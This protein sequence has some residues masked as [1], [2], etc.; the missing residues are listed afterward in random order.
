[1]LGAPT[2]GRAAAP[3]S[4]HLHAARPQRGAAKEG[5]ASGHRRGVCDVQPGGEGVAARRRGGDAR[6][7]SRPRP[8]QRAARRP[9]PLLRRV[10][11][12]RLRAHGGA[13]VRLPHPLLRAGAGRPGPLHQRALPHHAQ[14][15]VHEAALPGGRRLR[16]HRARPQAG[17]PHD[18]HH[19][20]AGAGDR[21]GGA[22]LLQAAPQAG[23]ALPGRLSAGHR[24][25]AAHA[26]QH[27]GRAHRA[28][29]LRVLQAPGRAGPGA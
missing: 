16:V 18:Q 20:A 17:L 10:L 8:H 15:C 23:P 7:P 6:R 5:H 26:R 13:G 19:G 11:H 22:V 14:A 3:S 28:A 4:A 21:H 25:S 27:R 29:A 2:A 12:R 24:H 1:M 9:R